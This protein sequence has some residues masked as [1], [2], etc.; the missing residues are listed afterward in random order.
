MT[1][2]EWRDL[3]KENIKENIELG[4][5]GILMEM[6]FKAGQESVKKEWHDCF[7]SCSSPYCAG[8]FPAVKCKGQ[9]GNLEKSE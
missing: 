8:V 3:Q 1:F 6:A 5:Y 7:L 4:S 2:D 9:T